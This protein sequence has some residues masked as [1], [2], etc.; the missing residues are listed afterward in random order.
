M[1][2]IALSGKGIH[3]EKAIFKFV[4]GCNSLFKRIDLLSDWKKLVVA[5]NLKRIGHTQDLD[6]DL[7]SYLRNVRPDF[8]S[9]FS[10]F[11]GIR[12]FFLNQCKA[13]PDENSVSPETAVDD[14][15][16]K[17]QK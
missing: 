17:P 16:Q 1:N 13:T 15:G 10:A 11:D 5:K 9:Q 7:F 3:D 2:G 6:I 8:W 4:E 12:K 14:S